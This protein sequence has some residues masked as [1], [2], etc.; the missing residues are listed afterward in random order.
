MNAASRSVYYFGFYLLAT[1]IMLTVFPNV[2]LSTVGIAP[3]TEVWIHLLGVV[4]FALG[5]Y[6]VY[7]APANHAL[8]TML[9]VYVRSMVFAMFLI[10]VVLGM[11]QPQ[12][13]LFGSIDL[14]CAIWTYMALRKG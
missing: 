2:M 14:V 10:F 11:A 4:V 12:L 8:F 9:T 7:M 1:G 13:M 3:T 6:Y 5:L